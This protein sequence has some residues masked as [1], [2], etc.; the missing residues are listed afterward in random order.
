MCLISVPSCQERLYFKINL[1]N[2]REVSSA[3]RTFKL[4]FHPFLKTLL[5]EVMLARS[6]HYS[7]ELFILYQFSVQITW[8][9]IQVLH[10]NSA[11]ICFIIASSN[12]NLNKVV[13]HWWKQPRR[14]KESR[15]YLAL[16]MEEHDLRIVI[17]LLYWDIDTWE[18]TMAM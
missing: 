12:G 3:E 14:H 17:R 2:S 13:M 7:K 16:K 5:M 15:A 8:F 10:T 1:F 6:L 18:N 11:D 4:D 9:V